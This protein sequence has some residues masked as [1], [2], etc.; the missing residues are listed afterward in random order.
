MAD[1]SETDARLLAHGDKA[2]VSAMVA[3]GLHKTAAP[4]SSR[5]ATREEKL[6]LFDESEKIFQ[7]IMA[8]AGG[9][10]VTDTPAGIN[11]E[12]VV[13]KGVDGNDIKLYVDT[14]TGASGPMP[15]A[16][17]FHGGG[18]CILTA[19]DANYVNFRQQLALQG[20]IVIGV[21]FRNIAGVNGR[22][23]YP[24]GLNDCMSALAWAHSQRAAR[25][26][27]K[28]IT[29]GESGG[30]NLSCAVALK[31]KKETLLNQLDGVYAFCPYIYGLYGEDI[32]EAAK[33]PSLKENDGIFMSAVGCGDMA[34]QYLP[35]GETPQNNPLAWPYW[36]SKEEVEGLPPHVIS[37]NELDFLRDEGV[38]YYRKLNSAGVRSRC[39]CLYGTP[40]AGESSVFLNAVPHMT[41]AAVADVA[42]FARSL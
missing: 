41:T 4:M 37:V 24:A 40:H 11:S 2:I 14:P 21:E 15:C 34:E 9:S 42:T 38:A 5:D 26:I 8:A 1:F 19:G 25:N 28:I 7:P 29:C 6:L 13:I 39:I 30:G 17:H 35:V 36:A 16:L 3:F 20:M 23:P 33:L 12:T 27:S 18:M 10:G 32:P 31:A 22:H